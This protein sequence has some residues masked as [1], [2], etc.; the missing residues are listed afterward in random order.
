MKKIV[1]LTSLFFISTISAVGYS[2][3]N[4]AISNVNSAAKKPP[5]NNKPVFMIDVVSDSTKKIETRYYE[6]VYVRYS[7]NYM[8]VDFR[9]MYPRRS[10]QHPSSYL[11]NRTCF[12]TNHWWKN[13]EQIN[14]LPRRQKN[15]KR[16]TLS[17]IFERGRPESPF[18]RPIPLPFKPMTDDSFHVEEYQMRNI[19][20]N[21][22][23]RKM[24]EEIINVK[25]LTG[26]ENIS[27]IDLY[28]EGFTDF[29]PCSNL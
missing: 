9:I 10:S 27:S 6:V 2:A 20:S 1:F 16:S 14:S 19:E 5:K 18:P 24:Y 25:F 17:F 13:F 28:N 3:V 15:S 22:Y 11:V 23:G 26:I 7:K 12:K 29:V 4:P 21:I 8:N